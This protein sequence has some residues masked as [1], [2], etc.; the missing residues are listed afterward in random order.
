MIVDEQH[1]YH[2]KALNVKNYS[3]EKTTESD[4]VQ[5]GDTTAFKNLKVLFTLVPDYSFEFSRVDDSEKPEKKSDDT[6]N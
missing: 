4:D 1:L 3:E 5:F 2:Q 6:Q